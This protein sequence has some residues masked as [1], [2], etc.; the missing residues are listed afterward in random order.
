MRGC[1]LA[2]FVLQNVTHRALQDSGPAAAV[3]IE[4]G[5][6]LAQLFPPTAGLNADHLDQFISQKR[7]KQSDR[8]RSTADARYQTIRQTIFFADDLSTR[9]AANDALKIAHHQG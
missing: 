4:S 5:R 1:D 2:A 3:R 6:V 8:I 9:F 7:V